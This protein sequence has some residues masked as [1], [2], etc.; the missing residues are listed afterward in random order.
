ML[1]FKTIKELACASSKRHFSLTCMTANFV[2]VNK[3]EKAPSHQRLG[4]LKCLLF[5]FKRLSDVNQIWIS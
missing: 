5:N 1:T 4:V 2:D 3:T